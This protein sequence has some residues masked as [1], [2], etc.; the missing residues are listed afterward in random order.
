MKIS[1]ELP[2][3][4]DPN[5]ELDD[6]WIHL[7]EFGTKGTTKSPHMQK[8]FAAINVA[9][10]VFFQTDITITKD[11]VESAGI[12]VDEFTLEFVKKIFEDPIRAYALQKVRHVRFDEISPTIEQKNGPHT[13]DVGDN[14][15]TVFTRKELME[16]GLEIIEQGGTIQDLAQ[17]MIDDAYDITE[18]FHVMDVPKMAHHTR[19]AF[20]KNAERFK[21]LSDMNDEDVLIWAFDTSP[22]TLKSNIGATIKHKEFAK[23]YFKTVDDA[24]NQIEDYGDT[25]IFKGRVRFPGKD[26]IELYIIDRT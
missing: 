6:A 25:F 18:Y 4:L 26:P 20:R 8:I 15:Y 11:F 21:Q 3:F 12:D 2:L 9:T 14:Q 5:A 7:S 23:M 10:D 19:E 16:Y 22:S 1:I 24:M 17:K 13:Y